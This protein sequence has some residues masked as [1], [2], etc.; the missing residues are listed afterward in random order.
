MLLDVLKI[1]L[2]PG[3]HAL[4]P[5]ASNEVWMGA[6]LR[7]WQHN[8]PYMQGSQPVLRINLS[9]RYKL[10]KYNIIIGFRESYCGRFRKGGQALFNF[11]ESMPLPN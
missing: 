3:P 10:L 4:D 9:K 8:E 2:G 1:Q 7:G 6:L 11:A 5:V